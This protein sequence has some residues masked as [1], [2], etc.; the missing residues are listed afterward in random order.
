[1]AGAGGGAAYKGYQKL[2]NSMSQ[3][4]Q[5][6]GGIKAQENAAEKLADER[7]G[8]RDQNRKDDWMK[9]HQWED[10]ENEITGYE[11]FDDTS[12]VL[13]NDVRNQTTDLH[14]QATEL[15]NSG[16]TLEADQVW[17]KYL[18]TRGAFKEFAK[19]Q[20]VL[21]E[22]NKNFKKDFEA[23]KVSAVD[24]DYLSFIQAQ[25][26]ID[27]KPK[28]VDGTLL[29]DVL[30]KDKD[31]KTL[32]VKTMSHADIVKNK[33]SYIPRNEM[34]GKDGLVTNILSSIGKRTYDEIKGDYKY[35]FQEWDDK[36]IAMVD[37]YADGLM[38]SDRTMSDLYYQATGEKKFG[39]IKYRRRGKQDDFTDAD[40]TIVKDWI[41]KQVEG[42]YDTKNTKD[43]R[44][45]TVTEKKREGA[46]GRSV[47][48]R[49]Q[50]L[51][52]SGSGNGLMYTKGDIKLENGKNAKS[53]AVE[54]GFGIDRVMKDA[55]GKPTKINNKF[56]TAIVSEDGKVYL[57]NGEDRLEINDTEQAYIANKLGF[58]TVDEFRK[59]AGVKQPATPNDFTPP[60][61]NKK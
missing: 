9:N 50:N 45:M 27:Y 18:K 49:G 46:L 28:V 19:I 6:W 33:Y 37:S 1:M 12:R 10:L 59:M 7:A 20:P 15:R 36:S 13:F 30:F 24:D 8:V 57:S 55:F 53:F 16:K 40:K 14:R 43:A 52:K 25:E 2:D 56:N 17:N 21:A 5:K 4:L 60:S 42:G 47:T 31:G 54:K 48:R 38:E 58:K 35:S 11:T 3:G 51:R 22:H 44:D 26:N 41:K 34:L 29:Y 61:S 32:D 23:G 39:N